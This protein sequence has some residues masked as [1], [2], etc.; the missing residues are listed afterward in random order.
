MR[1]TNACGILKNK[2]DALLFLRPGG[3]LRL[4]LCIERLFFGFSSLSRLKA[5]GVSSSLQG[6]ESNRRRCENLMV[7]R[8]K[9]IYKFLEQKGGGCLRCYS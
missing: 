1:D 3:F 6:K 2:R 9:K 7:F 8:P 4:D 5:R